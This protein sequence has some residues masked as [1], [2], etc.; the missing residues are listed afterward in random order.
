MSWYSARLLFE[1]VLK[2]GRKQ[3]LFEEKWIVCKSQSR[4]KLLSKLATLAIA[5]EHTYQN[6]E[7]DWVEIKFREVL[8]AQ[9]VLD[10][11][12]KDGT[13]VFFRFWHNPT[14]KEL[15]CLRETHEPA[16]WIEE[17]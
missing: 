13:E 11:Q 6:A 8:E 7:G 14:A 4:T 5:H 2:K 16:W 9:E 1:S 15:R 10:S 12:I 17:S 3:R